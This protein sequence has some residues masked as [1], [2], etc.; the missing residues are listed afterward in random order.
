MPK[1]SSLGLSC[2]VQ[3][4]MWQACL[5][6]LEPEH[7]VRFVEKV[8]VTV[9]LGNM[10]RGGI[11]RRWVQGTVLLQGGDSIVSGS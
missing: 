3:R 7:I 10:G 5:V 8:Q 1:T 9:Q 4:H 2:L 11:G 6:G